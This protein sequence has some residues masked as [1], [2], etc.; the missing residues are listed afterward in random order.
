MIDSDG[1]TGAAYGLVRGVSAAGEVDAAL[2][3]GRINPEALIYG[4]GL[5]RISLTA[6]TLLDDSPFS[7]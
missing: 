5:R 7:G 3:P 2:T 6:R 1:W 4:L